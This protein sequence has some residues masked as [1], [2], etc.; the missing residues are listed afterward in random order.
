MVL[1]TSAPAL[2]DAGPVPRSSLF[3]INS[4]SVLDSEAELAPLRDTPVGAYRVAFP[5]GLAE[6]ALGVPY[7]FESHDRLVSE[8]AR[9]HLRLL[10]VLN[11][12]PGWVTGSPARA[13]EPPQPGYES[14]RFELFAAAAARRFG[15]GGTFWQEHP[16]LPYL[17]VRHWEVW[18]EPN[19]PSFWFAGHPPRASE[20][21]L[22]LAAARRGLRRGDRRARIMFGGLAYGQAGVEPMRYMRGFLRERGASC[23]F[24]E[25]AIH[26]YSRSPDHALHEVQ[27]MRRLLDHAGR[28]D[29]GLW[30]TEYGWTTSADPS[31][32]FHVSEV[33]QRR[34]LLRLTRALLSRRRRLRL[35]GIY[36]FALRDAPPDPDHQESWGWGT[37]L[38]RLDGSAKP[39]FET[40]L[41]LAR[42]APKAAPAGHFRCH[43]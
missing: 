37:G 35:R 5:W 11:D 8:A 39:A 18:N 7:D 17:P 21:R 31:H 3:G 9:L 16:E 1:G 36:W 32:R 30:L 13:T 41:R 34:K 15:N 28:R 24:D 43:R 6:P 2:A 20:Y 25:V 29:A 22:L 10:P 12:S 27:A 23:L 14:D 33:G 38:L 26:P 42:K 4:W 40:Y 19:F